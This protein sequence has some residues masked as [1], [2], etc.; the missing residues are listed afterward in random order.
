MTR[1][2]D[3]PGAVGQHWPGTVGNRGRVMSTAL[4]AGLAAGLL[5]GALF[6]WLRRRRPADDADAADDEPRHVAPMTTTATT[7]ATTAGTPRRTRP[8]PAPA[9][10]SHPS[11]TGSFRAVVIRPGRACCDAVRALAGRPT[12]VAEAPTLP[13][14]G[15]DRA[16]CSC[17]F[18][19]LGDRRGGDERRFS[20]AGFGGFGAGS[21]RRE[22]RAGRDRRSDPRSDPRTD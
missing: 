20:L 16:Q 22:Q 10:A 5:A 3:D 15:C 4:L 8:P 21:T 1:R 9:P 14:A 6:A 12:L 18:Q 7:A 2:A 17:S 13:V 11:A 19:R